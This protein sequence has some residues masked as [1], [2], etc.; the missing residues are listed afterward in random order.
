MGQQSDQG[1]NA[2]ARR[3]LVIDDCSLSRI[4][5]QRS[6]TKAGYTVV[7]AETGMIALQALENVPE[8]SG[9]ARF[10][11]VVIDV[12]MPGMT[13]PEIVREIRARGCT[14][15]VIACS[16]SRELDIRKQ[17]LD[18]GCH[19]FVTKPFRPETIVRACD[20][21]IGKAA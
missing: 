14:V 12:N 9:F 20:D 13:G 1:M 3:A 10:D 2:Q 11:I 16:G 4:L 18:A 15:P 19:S 7:V 6:L 8:G 17:C 5:A 21:A